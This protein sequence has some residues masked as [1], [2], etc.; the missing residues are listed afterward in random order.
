MKPV[1]LQF[2]ILLAG[3]LLMGLKLFAWYSTGSVAILS[4]ALESMVNISA[5]AFAL[6]SLWLASRPSDK[7]HPYGHGKIEFISA[8]IEGTLV[9]L[10]AVGIVVK[11]I[12][13]LLHPE[14]LQAL[15]LGVMITLFCGLVHGILAWILRREARKFRS[16]TLYAES[17][18]LFSD[19]LSSAALALGLGLMFL[20]PKPWLD[21]VISLVFAA[22]IAFIGI[23]LIR[24]SL[25][26][27]MDEA[28]PE[29]LEEVKNI[30]VK[31]RK[32]EIIDIHNLRVIRYGADIHIDAHVTLPWYWDI[33]KGHDELELLGNE[34]RA[35]FS[36]SVEVFLHADPCLP[37]SCKL[38]ELKD[39]AV[40][41]FPFEH[42]VEWGLEAL[43]KNKRHN[44]N[45]P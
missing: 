2:W 16:Q 11:S 34:F 15:N 20:Y 24:K 30:C 9:L 40:R 23:R 4:D 43:C 21:P 28:D 13:A 37:S 45:S 7:E 8:L 32:E 42:K 31:A 25:G 14:P 33:Q 22:Y 26:G 35:A 3:F 19:A 41:S 29:V 10:A 44:L 12:S 5:G 6:F 18:H 1:R 39:C 38:C 36:S 17:G 27:I